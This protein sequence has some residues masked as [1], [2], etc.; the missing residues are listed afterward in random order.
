MRPSLYWRFAI[1]VL[2]LLGW[3]YALF[4]IRDQDF[5]TTFKTMAEDRL[6]DY[7]KELKEAEKTVAE[8]EKRLEQIED[9]TSD[10]YREVQADYTNAQQTVRTNER[11]LNTFDDLLKEAQRLL[12]EDED[13]RAPYRAVKLA[14]QER[15]ARAPIALRD[16][17]PVPTIPRASNSLV[18]SRVRNEARG[19]LRL[20]LDLKGGTEF[21]IG[22]D[23][24]KLPDGRS[25]ASVQNQII[26]ILRNRV[27][28]MG[29]VEPEIKPV[30]D[31]SISL[32]MPSVSE[33]EKA[34]VRRTIKQTARLTFHLVHE[35]NAKKVQEYETNPHTFD[36]E[37]GYQI[38]VMRTEQPDGSISEEKLFL[39]SRPARVK[40]SHINRAVASFNE[41]N[42]YYVSL[43]FN[44]EGASEFAKLTSDNVGRR[45]AIVL[46]GKVYSAPVIQQAI[47]G[48]QAQ[49]TGNFG[50]EE[51][52]R[53]ASVIDSGN[54]PVEIKI[55]SE[56]GTD[57][58][59]GKDSIRSGTLAAVIGLCAVLIFMIL[60]YRVAG[61]IAVV[62]LC[63]NILLVFGTLALTGATITLP[64]IAG[65]VLVIGMAVDAN[66]LI[67]ERI[68][69]EQESG[70][71]FGNALRSG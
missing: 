51:A 34:D 1:I 3:T 36:I 17:I 65:I 21:V 14:A 68:R 70:K 27:D 46:D 12:A 33:D 41:F 15:P 62:A 69:E 56:F 6:S 4:P 47:T 18:L 40:G 10:A 57:P 61:V 55:D 26:E 13:V 44:D 31:A 22:F 29:V 71:S 63:A 53:L 37:P 67:F 60:Y 5:M 11:L 64:G 25:P 42:N 48:G 49:I 16:Y 8:L 32:R 9:N 20:G 38:K 52:T 66:V 59:L 43:S 35:N 7:R 30:G 50:P 24:E 45:L 28:K 54:L 58:T 23:E 39:T 19:T 2:V